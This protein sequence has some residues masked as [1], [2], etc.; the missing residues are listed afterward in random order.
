MMPM[1]DLE[2]AKNE[3]GV[4]SEE[5]KENPKTADFGYYF[6][7]QQLNDMRKEIK[8]DLKEKS[9]EI[10]IRID[11]LNTKIDQVH[12]SLDQKIKAVKDSV[13]Q[14]VDS[15]DQKLGTWKMWAIGTLIAVL[16]TVKL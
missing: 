1:E 5:N 16:P 6:M 14:K 2:K 10:N 11:K 8:D 3:V 9:G 13:D 12:D 7:V 4:S 15:L